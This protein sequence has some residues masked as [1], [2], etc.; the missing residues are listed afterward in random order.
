MFRIIRRAPWIAIGAGTAYFLDGRSGAARRRDVAE[1][2]TTWA[3]RMREE[4]LE[5][6]GTGIATS[7]TA[8]EVTG[9]ITGEAERGGPLLVPSVPEERVR[10]RAEAPLAE[11]QTAGVPHPAREAMAEQILAE[12]EQRVTDRARTGTEHRR[13]E[14]TVETVEAA[15]GGA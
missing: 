12:S 5:R 15:S 6:P 7:P 14:E 10:S 3:R 9:G 8:T 2:A 11:E 4:W 1:R 13:S